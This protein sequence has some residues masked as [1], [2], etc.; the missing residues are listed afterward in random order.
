MEIMG[1]LHAMDKLVVIEA[2]TPI[3]Q[4]KEPSTY[5]LAF[6][7]AQAILRTADILKSIG[8]EEAVKL[9]ELD[10]CVK[11]GIHDGRYQM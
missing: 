7:N 2:L 5:A 8:I 1:Q 4:L 11:K 6:Q 10:L 9:A 3:K